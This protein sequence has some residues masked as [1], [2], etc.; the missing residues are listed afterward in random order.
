MSIAKR[1]HSGKSPQVKVDI[2]RWYLTGRTKI[3]RTVPHIGVM[4]KRFLRQ[5]PVSWNSMLLFKG[6]LLD[7]RGLS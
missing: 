2:G 4:R 5:H 7:C 6:L 3:K 1:L